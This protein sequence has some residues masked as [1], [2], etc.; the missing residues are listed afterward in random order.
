VSACQG[1]QMDEMRQAFEALK[2][3][4]KDCHARYK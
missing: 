2:R 3:M 4:K 1:N